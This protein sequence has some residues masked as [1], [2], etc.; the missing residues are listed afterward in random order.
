[1]T[2]DLTP[3][4]AMKDSGVEWL[5]DVP[6]H[7]KIE[8][9]RALLKVKS[10][11]NEGLKETTVLSLSYGRII[12]KPEEKLRGLVPES[13]ETYQIVD[14]GDII[15]R[16]TDLQND[17]TSLRVGHVHDRG[18]I[19]SAYLCL[20][21]QGELGNDYGY[22]L[23]NTYDLSKALYGYGSG[24]RQNLSWSD[25]KYVPILV[26][27]AQEQDAIVRFID[28][29]DR[30]IRRYIR[31]K[32]K[33]IKLLE[34]QKQAIIHQAVTGQIDVR[35]GKPYPAYRS[36]GVDW[37]GQ[38]P[39]HWE[40]LRTKLVFREVD[41]RSVAGEETHLSMSQSLG[42][43]PS[44]QVQSTLTSESYAGGKLCETGD[45]VLNRLKAHLGVFA[46][47]KQPGVISPDYSVFRKKRPA[48]PRYFEL[49][50][51]SPACRYELR[52]R[53]KG[54]VEGF[55][56]LYTDDFYGIRIPVPPVP[57]QDLIVAEADRKTADIETAIIRA[58]RE[59]ELLK[60]YRTRLIA[61]VVTGKLDVREAAAALPDDADETELGV[62]DEG[63]GDIEMSEEEAP[64]I[65]E[66]EE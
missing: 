27:T 21:P 22:Q 34:E 43:V 45:L 51:R 3:Y 66:E 62:D 14:P 29:I 56:R 55:W 12:V 50:L 19:T 17:R 15:I 33:L 37:L 11:P 36:S 65:N 53:A 25:F 57:E 7:W 2:A 39:S 9:G 23:L 16:S 26:P 63:P 58:N 20:Q 59:I 52:I 48:N 28:Y 18:I 8:P 38:V 41:V 46:L 13:F 5:G 10:V 24:L 47:A 49:A 61:D 64:E 31:A 6:D 4:P 60:E 40:V 44:D 54:I 30:R 42:L 35:T 1:M 32:R